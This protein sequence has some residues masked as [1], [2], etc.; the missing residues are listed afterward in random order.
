MKKK[1]L[2]MLVLSMAA[3][4]A[5]QAGY[6]DQR[7]AQGGVKI[8]TDWWGTDVEASIGGE[9]R[10]AADSGEYAS[11]K[12]STYGVAMCTVGDANGHMATCWT[13]DPQSVATV[14]SMGVS[15]VLRFWISANTGRCEW[16]E[17][18]N[19]TAYGAKLY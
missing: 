6:M 18:E 9:T 4:T 14:R 16:V 5:S 19:S 17:Y 11:C 13:S 1:L 10:Y 7:F 12:T 2:A 15:G 3:A 8:L